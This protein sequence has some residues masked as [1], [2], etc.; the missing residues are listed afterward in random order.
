[1]GVEARLDLTPS[2]TK[3]GEKS[4]S[5]TTRMTG[6]KALVLAAYGA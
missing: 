3:N 4:R 5:R 6:I 1:M 2:G